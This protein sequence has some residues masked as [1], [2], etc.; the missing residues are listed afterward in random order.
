[1][2]T[3]ET[4]RVRL[5]PPFDPYRTRRSSG[6]QLPFFAGLLTGATIV[7]LVWLGQAA[8][9]DETEPPLPT[10]DL[11]PAAQPGLAQSDPVAPPIEEP[12]PLAE[13]ADIGPLAEPNIASMHNPSK[14]PK[15]PKVDPRGPGGLYELPGK[16]G[17]FSYQG[18][19]FSYPRSW[20][21]VAGPG[22]I[23]LVGNNL[24][25]A[26]LGLDAEHQ[27]L[28]MANYHPWKYSPE[29][30]RTAT[31]SDVRYIVEAQQGRVLRPAAPVETGGVTVHWSDAVLRQASLNIDV[32]TR[33]YVFAWNDVEYLFAC[34][35][36]LGSDTEIIKGCDQI[37]SSL[38]LG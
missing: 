20:E 16:P 28:I 12:Q 23:G 26:H 22:Y 34:Q 7:G 3:L 4:T 31:D 18:L 15:G 21:L 29:Q 36:P 32:L 33:F 11:A 1:M 2:D 24:W 19:S 37:F 9:E 38:R 6:W 14:V 30:M 13:F 8:S 25:L 17:R 27:V 5:A 35:E 10:T